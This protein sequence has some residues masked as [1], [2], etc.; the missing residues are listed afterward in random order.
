M[1]AYTRLNTYQFESPRG[2]WLVRAVRFH[3][4]LQNS[5]WSG[6]G[7][8][9]GGQSGGRSITSEHFS[10]SSS[11]GTPRF[12]AGGPATFTCLMADRLHAE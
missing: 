6:V 1:R 12:A 4:A 10:L 9:D 5:S 8:V 3:D 2:L 11:K 7:E